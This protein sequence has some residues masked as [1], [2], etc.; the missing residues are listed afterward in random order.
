MP[1]SSHE[2]LN[3]AKRAFKPLS[4][5]HEPAPRVEGQDPNKIFCKCGAVMGFMHD[6]RKRT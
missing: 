3:R 4:H 2:N 6:P 1:T 5:K